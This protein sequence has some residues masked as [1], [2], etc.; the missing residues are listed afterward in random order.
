MPAGHGHDRANRVPGKPCRNAAY[1]ACMDRNT[2][3]ILDA[4]AQHRV[5]PSRTHFKDIETAMLTV[6][7]LVAA[8]KAQL[9]N[10]FGV[11]AKAYEGLEKLVEL[12]L[13]AGKSKLSDVA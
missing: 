7:Q 10:L 8:Q 9:G 5:C 1:F 4:A 2:Y 3:R 12:N 13:Q 11:T 6:E